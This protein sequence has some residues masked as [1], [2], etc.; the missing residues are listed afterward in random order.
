MTD[1]M[2][3][4]EPTDRSLRARAIADGQLRDLNGNDCLKVYQPF[5]FDKV[6]HL[7]IELTLHKD[8]AS[9]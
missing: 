1:L 7:Q 5:P 3:G 8:D 4:L 6:E 9:S 2:P